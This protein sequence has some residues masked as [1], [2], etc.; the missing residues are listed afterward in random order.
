MCGGGRPAIRLFGL[1][2]SATGRA[3]LTR[4]SGSPDILGS[5]TLYL[6]LWIADLQGWVIATGRPDVYGS[7]V[8]ADVSQAEWFIRGLATASAEEFVVCNV[9][10]HPLLAGKAVAAFS[11]AVRRAGPSRSELLGVLGIFF[12]WAPQ[13]AAIV[14][15]ASLSHEDH[16]ATRVMILDAA[17]RVLA[18]SDGAGLLEEIYPLVTGGRDR[19][20]YRSGET[21]VAFARN[22]GFETYKGLGW[23]GC[24]EASVDSKW[25]ADQLDERA[26]T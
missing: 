17:H 20:W 4:A 7:A 1:W 22:P 21:I 25:V 8:G 14:N 12:D 10:R 23:F 24:I 16:S 3:R 2:S 5:Y 6:D 15:N 11:T 19:G 9:A 18:A 26:S 13:A